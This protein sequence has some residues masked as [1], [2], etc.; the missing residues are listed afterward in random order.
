MNY[1][2]LHLLFLFRPLKHLVFLIIH[3]ILNFLQ[4]IIWDFINWN[5]QRQIIFLYQSIHKHIRICIIRIPTK[6]I[7][8][9]SHRYFTNEWIIEM[10]PLILIDG[11]IQIIYFQIFYVCAVMTSECPSFVK[12]YPVKFIYKWSFFK[13]FFF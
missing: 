5:R 8:Q 3:L 9:L 11:L 6:C 4:D 1:F 13:I 7:A 10:V 12:H 2:Q